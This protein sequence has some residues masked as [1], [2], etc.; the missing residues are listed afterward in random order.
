MRARTQSRDLGGEGGKGQGF[1]DYSNLLQYPVSI[2]SF[3]TLF[4]TS[5]DIAFG[6]G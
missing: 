2:L 4:Y 6:G 5:D 3:N 1:N